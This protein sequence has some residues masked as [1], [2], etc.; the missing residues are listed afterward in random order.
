MT[1]TAYLSI[2]SNLGDRVANCLEAIRLLRETPFVSIHK[3]SSLYETEPVGYAKQGDFINCV[4]EVETT[5]NA[6]M[7]LDLCL[8]IEN[9]I[10]RAETFKLGP[11]IIDIDILLYGSEIINRESKIAKQRLTIPHPHMHERRFVLAPLSEIAA[12]VIHPL[13]KKDIRT[14]LDELNDKKKVRRLCHSSID[15]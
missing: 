9:T 8:N 2:G 6:E 15:I 4:V 1:K 11:R 10:G 5:L 14:L 3:V 7:L 12:E 13:L